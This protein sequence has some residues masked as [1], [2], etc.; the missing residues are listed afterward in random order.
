MLAVSNIGLGSRTQKTRKPQSL[1]CGSNPQGQWLQVNAKVSL[2]AHGK[3]AY[4]IHQASHQDEEVTL[5]LR[6]GFHPSCLGISMKGKV[7]GQY[8]SWGGGAMLWELS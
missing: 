3:Q 1:P 6:D 2:G 7:R 8:R 4:L 5:F